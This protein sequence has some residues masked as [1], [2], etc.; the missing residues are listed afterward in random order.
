MDQ[1]VMTFV[2]FVNESYKT[3]E[4]RRFGPRRYSSQ[5]GRSS[6]GPYRGR[7]QS[8]SHPTILPK[9]TKR[10]EELGIGVHG[11]VD[12]IEGGGPQTINKSKKMAKAITDKGKLIARMVAIADK[13]DNPLVVRPF[14]D[15][16][17]ELNPDPKYAAAYRIGLSDGRYSRTIG[18]D[19]YDPDSFN[20]EDMGNILADLGLAPETMKKGIEG[21]AAEK[22]MY[23][24]GFLEGTQEATSADVEAAVAAVEA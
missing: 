24:A 9:D 15:R 6:Y 19:Q 18:T 17:L 13:Y 23:E 12:P 11:K 8:T 4:V 21:D 2:E 20:T 14:V 22:V 16:V 10:A 1:H 7:Y 5:R 3:N